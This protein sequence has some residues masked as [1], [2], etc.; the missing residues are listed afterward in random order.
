MPDCRS[1]PDIVKKERCRREIK[2]KGVEREGGRDTQARRASLIDVL[3]ERTRR[4]EGRQGEEGRK[5]VRRTKWERNVSGV[6]SVK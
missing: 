6:A 4:E 3:T 2:T 5:G 1:T